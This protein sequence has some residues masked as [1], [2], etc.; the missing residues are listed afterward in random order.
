[1]RDINFIH[2]IAEGKDIPKC[3]YCDNDIFIT[4]RRGSFVCNNPKCKHKYLSDIQKEIHKNNPQLAINA[5]KRQLDYLS[6]SKNFEITPYGLR[7][8][9][10][11]HI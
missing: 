4:G 6:N 11:Y 7:A 1:M 9:K 3:K 8:N 10:N 2:Y 5:R